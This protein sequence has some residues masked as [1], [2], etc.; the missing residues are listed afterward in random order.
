MKSVVKIL[1]SLAFA[2][3]L[4][5]TN[6]KDKEDPSITPDTRTKTQLIT[7]SEWKWTVS[8]C[9]VPVDTD[10][11]DGASTNLLI[12]MLP[13]E[14]D[15][16]YTF[17]SDS[18]M[19]EKTN[20]KCKTNEPV[21]WKGDWEFLNNE[22]VLDWDGDDHG[23]PEVP[24][25]YNEKYMQENAGIHN[26]VKVVGRTIVI[27]DPNTFSEDVHAPRQSPGTASPT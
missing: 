3:I 18:T 11:K 22:K 12:Q 19:I 10:G 13:C 24:L 20:V 17:K 8:A 6:C 9:N 4:N 14:I 26:I 16:S 25:I 23:P 5:L 1:T 21:S 27:L 15:N 2:A 7:A